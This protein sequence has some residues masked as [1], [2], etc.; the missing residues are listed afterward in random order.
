MY[1]LFLIKSSHLILLYKLSYIHKVLRKRPNKQY[2]T[3]YNLFYLILNYLS[4]LFIYTYSGTHSFY[5]S[6]LFT[7]SV[8]E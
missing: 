1:M 4:T 6:Y 3:F 7:Q 2:Y 5:K 8:Q